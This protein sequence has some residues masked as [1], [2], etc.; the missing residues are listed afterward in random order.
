MFVVTDNKA[1]KRARTVCVCI[2]AFVIGHQRPRR[3][4]DS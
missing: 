2:L 1:A 3:P 4:G